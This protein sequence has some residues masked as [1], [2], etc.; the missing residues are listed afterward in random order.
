MPRYASVCDVLLAFKNNDNRFGVVWR[1]AIW[2][3]LVGPTKCS[4]N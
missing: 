4:K 3:H 1:L 2:L